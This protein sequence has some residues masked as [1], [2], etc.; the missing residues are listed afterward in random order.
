MVSRGIE[1]QRV[2]CF[3]IQEQR[4]EMII[5]PDQ[6][7]YR[8]AAPERSARMADPP[9]IQANVRRPSPL[10]AMRSH[11]LYGQEEVRLGTPAHHRPRRRETLATSAHSLLLRLTSPCIIL[12]P[13][14]LTF[15]LQFA[16][17]HYTSCDRNRLWRAEWASRRPLMLRA[18][19]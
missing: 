4:E 3:R 5:S 11:P 14:I 10:R 18:T 9:S 12:P 8:S 6:L 13:H 1:P 17:Q 15:F 19:V 16:C 7:G 2:N